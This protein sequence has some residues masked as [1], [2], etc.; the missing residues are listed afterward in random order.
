MARLID[1]SNEGLVSMHRCFSNHNGTRRPAH[2]GRPGTHPLTVF[3][4]SIVLAETPDTADVTEID[5]PRRRYVRGM[6]LLVGWVAL[7]GCTDDGDDAVGDDGTNEPEEDANETDADEDGTDTDDTE[8]G[9]EDDDPEDGTDDEEE[10]TEPRDV[11]IDAE[12]GEIEG[13]LTGAGECGIVLTPQIN[14]DRQSWEQQATRWAEES[15]VLAI[16]PV[17]EEWGASV[18]GAVDYL[19]EEHS[20]DS[21]VLIGASVGGEGSVIAAA[22]RAELVT[23]VVS[24]S[25]GG[26]EDRAGELTGEKLFVV[27]ED[28]ADRFVETAEALHEG[29]EDPKEL[30]KYEGSTHGQG[31]FD[32]EHED[33]LLAR[34]DDLIGR[35]CPPP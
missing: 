4:I 14:L 27:A 30:V 17:D 2:E 29:A 1:P 35:A 7:A 15:L 11:T 24:L 8:D 3:I 5:R 31:L 13:T 12:V 16:D 6:G 23:G 21:V 34:I 22:E 19:D 18:V 32:T 26:G 28:D 20:V 9:S 25:A 33:D 10:V